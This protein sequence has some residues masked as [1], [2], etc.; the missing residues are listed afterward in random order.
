MMQLDVARVPAFCPA[1]DL[2]AC[3]PTWVSASRVCL[4]FAQDLGLLDA[5]FALSVPRMPRA[6]L[7]VPPHVITLLSVSWELARK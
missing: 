5:V 2:V 6:P 1:S 3:L 4:S 7:A